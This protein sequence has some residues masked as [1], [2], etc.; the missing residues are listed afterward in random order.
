MKNRAL[1]F[2]GLLIKE[3]KG[4]SSLCLELDVA[5]CGKTASL[6][7][8]MLQE[9]VALHLETAIES[10]LPYLRSVPPSENPLFIS[11]E[12]V[13]EKFDLDVDVRLIAHA[14]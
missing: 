10:N 2:T 13:A 3:A 9:A 12:T 5:S 7:K 11:P 4:F 6:A 14:A 8:R 1:R